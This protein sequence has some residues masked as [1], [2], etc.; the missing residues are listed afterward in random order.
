[1]P[2]P[3]PGAW[4]VR[5]AGKGMFFLVLLAKT[6]LSLD[7][8]RFVEPGGRPGH[9]GLFPIKG[10]PKRGVAQKLEVAMSGALRNPAF[11]FDLVIRRDDSGTV[12]AAAGGRERR[13]AGIPGRGDAPRPAI[14]AR[15]LGRG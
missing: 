5:V 8:V 9:E 2:K 7:S 4:T 11:R 13:R 10:S 1:M 6:D 12:A 15:G 3:T 14:P